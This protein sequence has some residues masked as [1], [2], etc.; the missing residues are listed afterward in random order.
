MLISTSIDTNHWAQ[1]HIPN[2]HD[3]MAI[4]VSDVFGKLTIFN[5]YND[6]HNSDMTDT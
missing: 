6:C 2:M 1:L 4:Q 5:L 3:L